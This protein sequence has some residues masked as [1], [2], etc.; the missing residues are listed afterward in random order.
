MMAEH[1]EIKL[2]P[3]E[4]AEPV[5]RALVRYSAP[6]LTKAEAAHVTGHGS[7]PAFERWAKRHG[8]RPCSHGRYARHLVMAALEYEAGKRSRLPAGMAKGRAAS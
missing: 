2:L 3:E 1:P 8:V 4:L 5:A 6:V 7:M